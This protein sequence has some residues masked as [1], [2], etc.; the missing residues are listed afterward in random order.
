M[1]KIALQFRVLSLNK[2]FLSFIATYVPQVIECNVNII[3]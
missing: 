3:L 1:H 2:P